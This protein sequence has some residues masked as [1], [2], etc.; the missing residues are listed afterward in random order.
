MIEYF[1]A[2]RGIVVPARYRAIKVS[3]SAGGWF[4]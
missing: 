4:K 1:S 3:M 2:S